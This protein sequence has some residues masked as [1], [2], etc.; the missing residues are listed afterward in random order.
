M[1]LSFSDQHRRI[2]GQIQ[3]VAGALVAMAAVAACQNTQPSGEQSPAISSPSVTST[4]VPVPKSAPVATEPVPPT[5]PTAQQPAKP[6]PTVT[7]IFPD[8]D[9]IT[10]LDRQALTDILGKP[11]FTRRDEPAEIWQYRAGICT[12]DVFLHQNEAGPAYRVTHFESRTHGTEPLTT[13]DCFVNL[14]KTAANK[15]AG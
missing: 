6:N 10:G 11:G 13:K 1:T 12:L 9:T 15:Q 7:E 3:A 2:C 4:P 5:Q 8:P 14:L